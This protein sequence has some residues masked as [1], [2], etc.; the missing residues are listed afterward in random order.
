MFETDCDH[1]NFK[2]RDKKLEM[3]TSETFS[4]NQPWE[5]QIL[6]FRKIDHVSL[7]LPILPEIVCYSQQIHV[8]LTKILYNEETHLKMSFYW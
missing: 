6:E 5:H 8:M 1:P 3:D 2:I 4:E 7:S